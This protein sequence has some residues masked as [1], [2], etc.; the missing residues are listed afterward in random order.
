MQPY[1]K[2]EKAEIIHI[3]V[4][5]GEQAAVL[6]SDLQ[7]GALVLFDGVVR[8]APVD[9]GGL[10]VSGGLGVGNDDAVLRRDHPAVPGHRDGRQH[11]VTCGA[12]R[13]R[14]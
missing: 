7:G 11:V 2:S 4:L 10:A 9:P 12:D 1:L 8:V 14:K 5:V 6:R 3:P 13:H